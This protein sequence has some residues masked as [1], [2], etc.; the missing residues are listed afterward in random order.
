ML[1]LTIISES[2]QAVRKLELARGTSIKIGRARECDIRVAAPTVSRHHAEVIDNGEGWTFRDT[3]STHG[4]TVKGEKVGEVNITPGLEIRIGPI[5]L[6]FDNLASRIGRE[7]D[8]LLD[9]DDAIG[10]P[11]SVE[12]IGREGRHT[13]TLD[14]TMLHGHPA[15]P[16]VVTDSPVRA[17]HPR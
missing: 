14:E 1:E 17:R 10:G 7:L 2:G 6:R 5:L 12:I 15:H 3:E 11:V 9:D 4:S 16:E 13:T 8:L